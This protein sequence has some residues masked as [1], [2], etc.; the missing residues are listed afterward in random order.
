MESYAQSCSKCNKSKITTHKKNQPPTHLLKQFNAADVNKQLPPKAPLPPTLANDNN[1]NNFIP[2]TAS[3]CVVD[4]ATA[5]ARWVVIHVTCEMELIFFVVF[6]YWFSCWLVLAATSCDAA[7]CLFLSCA[8]YF[9]NCK[10]KLLTVAVC[11]CHC[12]ITHFSRVFGRTRRRER[13]NWTGELKNMV[14]NKNDFAYKIVFVLFCFCSFFLIF[15][16]WSTNRKHC[17]SEMLLNRFQN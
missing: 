3:Y 4:A 14:K 9:M 1:V 10:I 5:V 11:S 12:T 7:S 16:H 13:M 6:F 2:A 15:F 8:L 17:W